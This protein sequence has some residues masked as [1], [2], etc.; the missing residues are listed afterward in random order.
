MKWLT[1]WFIH[2]PVAANLLMLAMIA[3]GLLSL[4][5]LRVESFP[6]IAPSSLTITIAYPGGTAQQIDASVTQ[7]I[8]DALGDV[9]GIK[10]LVSQS[11]AGMAQIRVQKKSNADLGKLL[12]DVRNRVNSIVGLPTQAERPQITR[13]DFT[14]LAAFVIISSKQTAQNLQSIARQV[15]LALKQHPDITK[16]TNLGERAPLIVIEPNITQLQMV[17]LNIESLAQRI[18]Q[19]S[20]ETRSGELKSAQGRITLRGDG[21][22]D[23][24]TLLKQLDIIAE[25]SGII[26]LDDIATIYRDYEATGAI[27]RNNGESAIALQI[28][29]SQNDNLLHISQAISSV[30]KEQQAL[31]PADISLAVMAD[32]APY[33]EDQLNRLTNNAWQGLLIVLVILGLFLRLRLAMWVALGIPIA[34]CG[35]LGMMNVLNYS[36]ND[37]TLFG[38]ILVLG[39]LV[40][41]AVVVGESIHE[42]RLTNPDPKQAAFKGV[43]S[44]AVATVFGVLTTVAAFSPMLWINNELAKLL[45]SFSAVVIIALL[46]SLIESKFILP[47]HLAAMP[48]QS[49]PWPIVAKLQASAQSALQRFNNQ[50]YAP[51]LRYAIRHKAACLI[52]FFA[53]V[54][55]AYGLWS[56]GF[57]RSSAFPEIPGRYLSATITLTPG[58]PLPLQQQAQ[59]Q[60]EQGANRLNQQLQH[61]YPLSAPPITN[62]LVWST[63]YGEIEATVELTNE[64]LTVLPNNLA[65]N[66]W[67]QY[68]GQFEGAYAV[69]FSAADAP[70]GGT[71]ISISSADHALAMQASNQLTKHLSTL[72]GV[73]DVYD[74]GQ[75]GQQQIRIT[76][77]EFGH[78]LGL[79]QQQIALMIGGAYGEREIHRLLQ[80]GQ[81]TKVIL[82]YQAKQK[83]TQQQLLQTPIFLSSGKTVMLGDVA[84]LSF[85]RQPEVVHRRDRQQVVNLYWRQDRAVQSPEQTLQQLK[86][87]MEDLATRYPGVQIQSGGEFEELGEI[88]AGFKTAMILTLLLIYALLA[89][90]LKSYWQPLIIMAVIPFG[91]AGA[92]I[93]HGVMD[94]PV[95]ILSLFGMMAMTG[96]VINDS[97]VLMTRFNQ[98]YRAGMPLNEA[99]IKAGTSRLRAIFLTTMTTVCGLLPL[100]FESAEQ[101]QYLKPAAVSLVFGELF[102]TG[103]TLIII[104]VLLGLFTSTEQ[105]LITS[106]PMNVSL[107]QAGS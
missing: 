76:L 2:N 69:S 93:G 31:L 82:R 66:Q 21:Y 9:A 103:I 46:F 24:L 38:I 44:V 90:P 98:Y 91:F 4:S 57:I 40:D 96:I 63:G 104:P 51:L 59:M 65:L 64:A 36:I 26:K 37:I 89:V 8:E 25:P 14:N 15:A 29:T 97:L 77:N 72:S 68:S 43:E 61:D 35:T 55:L 33:I 75:G 18:E 81:E 16:V 52:S 99:L 88:Q 95:S 84:N 92:I 78:Q 7:R 17:G 48:T 5:Q 79:T 3:S 11:S 62:L 83:A 13:E 53:C 41:D 87:L 42:T 20:I 56:T 58:A 1:H 10:R 32:M 80:Q 74:D 28:N 105:H 19:M 6:Q 22:A 102:A 54:L 94:L 45:A 34:L 67:Q 39:I 60:L 70:A 100:L 71:F 73:H 27:V 49:K 107:E 85:E 12:E 50:C 101:A 23:N 30:L 106:E 86:P 47:S